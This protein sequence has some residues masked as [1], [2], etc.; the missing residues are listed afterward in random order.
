MTISLTLKQC[1][2]NVSLNND[3]A[4]SNVAK[5]YKAYTKSVLLI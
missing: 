2:I 4:R 1:D 5:S 3:K